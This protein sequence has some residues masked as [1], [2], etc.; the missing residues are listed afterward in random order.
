MATNAE[1]VVYYTIL[2]Y[3]ILYYIIL[4]YILYYT[5]LYD[6]ILYYNILYYTILYYT[7]LYYTILYYTIL[8]YTLYYTILNTRGW[9]LDPLIQVMSKD[10]FDNRTS[11]WSKNN[12]DCYIV[13]RRTGRGD[14]EVNGDLL[15]ST[16]P[17]HTILYS[18]RLLD[19][20][21]L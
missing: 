9:D 6:T 1:M 8:Y 20:T 11:N 3:Y 17:Y 2:Y 13:F 19:Y 14:Y 10:H 15:K 4:Y 18:N 5:I 21:I 7:M 16:I 12:C